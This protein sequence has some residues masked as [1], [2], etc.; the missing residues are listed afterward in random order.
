MSW[1]KQITGASNPT[2]GCFTAQFRF[3][4]FVYS[5]CTALSITT[6][7]LASDN[8]LEAVV[9]GIRDDHEKL[10]HFPGGFSFDYDV[11][12][13]QDP[14]NPG[15]VFR[16][17]FKGHFVVKWPKI[18]NTV[19][20][21]EYGIKRFEKG[22]VKTI[23]EDALLDGEYDF[24]TMTSVARNGKILGQIGGFRHVYNSACVFPLTMQ[25]FVEVSQDYLPGKRM[26]TDYW[27]PNAIE[28]QSY[29]LGGDE[30]VE[31]VHCRV[32]V[33][34]G[35]DKLW[36]ASEQGYVVCKR[37]LRFGVGKPIRERTLSSDLRELGPGAWIPMRQVRESYDQQHPDEQPLRL[38]LTVSN[39]RVGKIGDEELKVEMPKDIH[40]VEDFVNGTVSQMSESPKGSA[41][42]GPRDRAP[43]QCRLH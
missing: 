12:V 25:C 35:V 6:E 24:E 14:E 40:R 15:F 9:Q 33:R 2:R 10:L 19:T 21:R 34:E 42:A 18:R 41:A 39:L 5:L 36:L 30:T 7:I 37:E 13:Q 32:L 20:G 26:E 29:Q 22:E 11:A 23:S 28:Q 27:L 38:T 31:G 4:L 8:A 16:D 1:V 3:A 43:R 17:G